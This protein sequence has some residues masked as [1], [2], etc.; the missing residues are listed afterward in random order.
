M[1][2][3]ALAL[4]SAALV[5]GAAPAVPAEP[6]GAERS[7]VVAA[8]AGH[9]SWSRAND[10]PYRV[11]PAVNA[12]CAPASA[13]R[14]DPHAG[15][16]VTVFVNDAGRVAMFAG[17]D[18]VFPEGSVIVK[19]KRREAGDA[20]PVLMTVMVKRERGYDPKVGDWEFAVVDGKGASVLEG[21]KLASCAECHAAK[22]K[23]D[24]VFRSYLPDVN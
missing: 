21:G 23:S 2:R 15:A 18:A 19:E 12:L 16:Y 4:A 22:A 8:V 17:H 24:F 13:S 6:D 10:K 5:A 3:A 1:R 7:D 14:P 9:G 20:E 11:S